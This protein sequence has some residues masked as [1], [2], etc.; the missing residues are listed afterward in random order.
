MGIQDCIYEQVKKRGIGKTLR[1]GEACTCC[2]L[3]RT[4][5]EILRND[6]LIFDFSSTPRPSEQKRRWVGDLRPP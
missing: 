1:M 3:V 5:I 6:A 2:R 4:H